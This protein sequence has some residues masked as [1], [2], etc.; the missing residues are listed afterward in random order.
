[1]VVFSHKVNISQGSVAMLLRCGGIFN[2]CCISNFLEIATAKKFGNRPI[3][4]EVMCRAIKIGV[5]FFAVATF[6]PRSS[7]ISNVVEMFNSQSISYNHD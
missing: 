7:H 5:S 2:D 3:F 1:M 6:M 4:D